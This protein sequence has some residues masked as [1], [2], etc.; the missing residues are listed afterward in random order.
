MAP[1]SADLAA[2][3]AKEEIRR[4]AR[5][6]RCRSLPMAGGLGRNAV[7]W[8]EEEAVILGISVFGAEEAL[9]PRASLSLSPLTFAHVCQI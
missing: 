8:A 6:R 5:E 2:A 4:T 7:R 3:E 1:S 9:R